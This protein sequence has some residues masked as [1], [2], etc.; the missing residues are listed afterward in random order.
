M[1]VYRTETRSRP[2]RACV[3]NAEQNWRKLCWSNDLCDKISNDKLFDVD[4][5][6]AESGRKKALCWID[7]WR[8]EVDD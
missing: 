4:S 6:K 7:L 5:K 8:S 2:R 3:R 1:P